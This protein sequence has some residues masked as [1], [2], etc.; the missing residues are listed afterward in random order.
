MQDTCAFIDRHG[1]VCYHCALIPGAVLI[2]R[3]IAVVGFHICKTE[4]R[5][6]NVLLFHSES[7]ILPIDTV[8][9]KIFFTIIEL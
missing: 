6:V 8:C 5:P 3:N 2:I 4:V 9:N 7:S 1:V